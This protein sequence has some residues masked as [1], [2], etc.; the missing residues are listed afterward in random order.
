[1]DVVVWLTQK[2]E[3]PRPCSR[4][5]LESRRVLNLRNLAIYSICRQ[6][7]SIEPD[8]QLCAV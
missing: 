7:D 6:F 2:G 5:R 4:E 1:M 8:S 3:I